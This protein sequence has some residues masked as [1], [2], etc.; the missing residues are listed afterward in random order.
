MEFLGGNSPNLPISM[1]SSLDEEVL[2]VIRCNQQSEAQ[3]EKDTTEEDV[4]QN[5][6]EF[7][8]WVED[9]EDKED[10]GVYGFFSRT[11]FTSIPEMIEF[12]KKMFQFDLVR[13]VEA[14]CSNSYEFIKFVNFIRSYLQENPSVQS[15]ESLLSV[16]S[17]K[18][19]LDD[20]F[21][22]PVLEHDSLLFLYEEYFQFPEEDD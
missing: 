3:P 15:P 10:M 11:K 20:K 19:F 16:I 21:L 6:K 17:A 2:E 22:K 1:T 4:D 12:E 14:S 9:D 13:T 18:E 8:D 5:D 7:N